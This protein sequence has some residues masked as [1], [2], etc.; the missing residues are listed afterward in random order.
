MISWQV[1]VPQVA[2]H[3]RGTLMG[4]LCAGDLMRVQRRKETLKFGH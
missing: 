2:A 1:L 4:A 3:D